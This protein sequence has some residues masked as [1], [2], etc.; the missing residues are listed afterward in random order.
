MEDIS[1]NPKV[2]DLKTFLKERD[3]NLSGDKKSQAEKVFG[4]V[5]LGLET[6]PTRA[7]EEERK[8][9]GRGKEEARQNRK[10]VVRRRTDI[11][12]IP[13]ETSNWLSDW[14]REFP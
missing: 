2:E 5:T 6:L 10:I 4:A 1:R 7:E 13:T 14:K 3:I 12:T 9:K 8:R 11:A